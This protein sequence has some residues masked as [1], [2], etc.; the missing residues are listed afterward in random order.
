MA[1]MRVRLAAL[2]LSLAALVPAAPAAAAAPAQPPGRYLLGLG[3]SLTFGYQPWR[4]LFDADSFRTGFVD[5]LAVQL[6][7]LRP[8]IRAV[9][10]GCPG[11]TTASFL[12]GGC[13]Y[14]RFLPLHDDYP[15][16]TPQLDQAL[17]FLRE[18]PG[19]V[20]PIVIS[21]GANDL[22]RLAARCLGSADCEREGLPA[23]LERVRA[24]LE[25]ILG[26]LDAAAPTATV[27]LLAY[28]DPYALSDPSSIAPVLALNATI[29]AAAAAH[30][31]LVADAFAPFNVTPPQPQRLC[32]L[33]FACG[34]LPDIHPTDAG[35]V[36]IAGQFFAAAGYLA[37]AGERYRPPPQ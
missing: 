32:A 20:S 15:A 24:N 7:A 23:V 25:T 22:N 17:A 33:T 11:E 35:H 18:H 8:D 5:V 19:E 3:D 4:Y 13:P 1:P 26:A 37:L 6:A 21:I 30:G 10:Y 28:Y 16:E 34:L 14:N 12:E 36:V 2:L 29:A 27:A 9:N 31:D